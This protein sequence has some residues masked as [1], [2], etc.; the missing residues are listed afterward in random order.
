LGVM[1]SLRT[2]YVR[3][4][5]V[6]LAGMAF[7]NLGFIQSEITLLNLNGDQ[8]LFQNIANSTFE[9]ES[10]NGPESSEE[11]PLKEV[12][13]FS[14]FDDEISCGHLA[15][16]TRKNS[17]FNSLFLNPGYK[18]TFSPPPEVFILS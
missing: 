17:P 18:S 9:E 4:L 10:E 15:F 13:D 8:K 7:F 5:I 6:V 11:D 1:K 14:I 2:S 3:S 16:S 12:I